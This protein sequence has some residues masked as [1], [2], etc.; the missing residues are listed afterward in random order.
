MGLYRTDECSVWSCLYS[1][2]HIAFSAWPR[3]RLGD[4]R[5][6]RYMRRHVLRV[7]IARRLRSLIYR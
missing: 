2:I 3:M 7:L 5:G 1:M 4:D 6:I